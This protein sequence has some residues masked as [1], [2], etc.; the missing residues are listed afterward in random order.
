MA[1]MKESKIM[2]SAFDSFRIKSL[3]DLRYKDIFHVPNGGFRAKQEAW[4]LKRQGVKSGVPDIFVD[5]PCGLYH[6]ARIEVKMI[7]GRL[8]DTQKAY[9]KR[10]GDLNFWVAVVWCKDNALPIVQAVETYLS[11]D[12]VP[13]ETYEVRKST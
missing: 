11:L 13:K 12:T 10:A 2:E 5:Y 6:G 7:G 4:S 1:K 3:K 9:L 8:S